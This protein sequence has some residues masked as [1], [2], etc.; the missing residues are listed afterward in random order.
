MKVELP[1]L[2]PFGYEYAHRIVFEVAY[3]LAKGEDHLEVEMTRDID[4]REVSKF[5]EEIGDD[6]IK[7]VLS[8]PSQYLTGEKAKMIGAHEGQKT[9]RAIIKYMK[10]NN[11]PFTDESYCR[12]A[13]AINPVS[14]TYNF[15]IEAVEIDGCRYIKLGDYLHSYSGIT[16]IGGWA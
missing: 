6:N 4:Y 11:I 5:A 9:S 13:D 16:Y 1:L 3:A 7:A 12:F 2:Q 15:K 8:E 10:A 14:I